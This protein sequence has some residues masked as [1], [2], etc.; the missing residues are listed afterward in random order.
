MKDTKVTRALT[1]TLWSLLILYAA[2]FSMVYVASRLDT[3]K[4]SEVIAVLGAAQYNG[5]PSPVFKARLD[6]AAMLYDSGYSH[7]VAVTGGTAE[8][9]RE[10]EARVGQRYL[11]S[12]GVPDTAA[13]AVAEGRDTEASMAALAG[14]MNVA[15]LVAEL[16]RREGFMLDR[17]FRRRLA[18][19]AGACAAMGAVLFALVRVLD[20]APQ[21]GLI[22]QAVSLIV[23]IAGGF[24]TYLA[25]G[26][27]LGALQPRALLKDLLGR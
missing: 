19:I 14:W 5:R 18:G 24:A 27:L 16:A 8:G 7:R 21:S 26:T 22:V 4:D 6:H 13:F 25:A 20:F 3:R 15:L 17:T 12:K 23:L 11:E 1:W 2:S 10:S 9:D